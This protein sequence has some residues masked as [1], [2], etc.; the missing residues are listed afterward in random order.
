M[1]K[2]KAVLPNLV[3]SLTELALSESARRI[4]GMTVYCSFPMGMKFQGIF[5][6]GDNDNFLS[7][8]SSEYNFWYV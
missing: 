6:T 3:D 7:N 5:L 1:R 8:F 4:V 2:F